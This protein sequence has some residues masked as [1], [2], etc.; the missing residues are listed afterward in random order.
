MVKSGEI[1]YAQEQEIQ[2]NLI[3]G[4]LKNMDSRPRNIS[5]PDDNS[6]G[7]AVWL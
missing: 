7:L 2:N 3:N 4:Q 1:F 5:V 6:K